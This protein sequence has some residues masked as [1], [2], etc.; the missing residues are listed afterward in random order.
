MPQFYSLK[1][2]TR[3]VSAPSLESLAFFG[4]YLKITIIVGPVMLAHL[5]LSNF[6]TEVNSDI[7]IILDV[8]SIGTTLIGLDSLYNMTI[9]H[10]N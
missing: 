6:Y 9:I 7:M 3:F 1:L 10:F 4:I 2:H 5:L 8:L